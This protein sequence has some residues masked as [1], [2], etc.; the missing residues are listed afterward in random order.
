MDDYTTKAIHEWYADARQNK[1]GVEKFYAMQLCELVRPYKK[2]IV[3]TP[4]GLGKKIAKMPFVEW[5][6]HTR[7][8]NVYGINW[9]LKTESQS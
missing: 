7:K 9:D 6:E 8:G 4:S 3:L 5:K 2:G 1:T